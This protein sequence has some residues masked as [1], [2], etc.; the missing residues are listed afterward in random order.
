MVKSCQTE[1]AWYKS[2]IVPFLSFF[3]VNFSLLFYF[4][5][6]FVLLLLLLLIYISY[7]PYWLLA[8]SFHFL[9]L[10]YALRVS[11]I[12]VLLVYGRLSNHLCPIWL[13]NPVSRCSNMLIPSI[14]FESK[15]P[16]SN[17]LTT[18]L[19]SKASTLMHHSNE[20]C[21]WEKHNH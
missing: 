10:T 12:H 4:A 6:I 8:L 3:F 15:Q 9:S 21:K 19:C 14:S 1:G 11:A 20:K 17:S 16:E 5:R 7:F 13:W 18:Q 2:C